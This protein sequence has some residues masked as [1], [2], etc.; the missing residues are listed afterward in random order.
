ME[1]LYSKQLIPPC[2]PADLALGGR[3]SCESELN[4]GLASGAHQTPTFESYASGE[5]SFCA[6]SFS[7]A[8]GKSCWVHSGYLHICINI[9]KFSTNRI[10]IP[11]CLDGGRAIPIPRL[12]P[13][14]RTTV[15]IIANTHVDCHPACPCKFTFL[16]CLL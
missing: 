5:S 12:L 8:S 9:L 6:Y 14:L 1:N 13:L 16:I 7:Y 11:I 3:I 15:E 10:W 4:A 2:I